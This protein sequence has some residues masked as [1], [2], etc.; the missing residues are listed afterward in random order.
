MAKRGQKHL[1]KCQCVVNRLD[2]LSDPPSH[3]FVVFSVLDDD[4]VISKLVQCNNCGIV[5][6]VIDLGK[7][8]ILPGV[9]HSSAIVSIED[10][11]AALPSKL[12]TLL[13]KNNADL[14]T[15]EAAQFI[16]ENEQWNEYVVLTSELTP[17]SRRGKI[18]RFLGADSFR[19]ESF[20]RNEVV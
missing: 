19:V 14:P 17:T 10:I 11:S 20:D 4:R 6:D 18:L 2:R 1:I 3:H 7:S 5:H 12:C 16:I 8:N 13:E 9:E 15:W